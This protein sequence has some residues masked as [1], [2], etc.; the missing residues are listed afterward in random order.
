MAFF[1]RSA[2]RLASATRPC[3]ARAAVPNV[4]AFSQGPRLNEIIKKYTEDHEWVSLDTESRIATIGVTA[5]A[6]NSLGDVVYVELPS[7][8][9][10]VTAGESFGAVE[11]VKSASDIMAPVSGEVVESNSALEDKPGLINKSPEDEAWIVKVQL[12]EGGEAAVSELMDDAAYKTFT[13]E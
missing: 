1:A 13:E 6:A 12:A 2:I 8:S 5:Y 11:S 3:V 9:S 4:R 10:E 7:V